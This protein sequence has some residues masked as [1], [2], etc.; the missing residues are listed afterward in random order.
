MKSVLASLVVIAFSASAF[1]GRG[2]GGG[3]GPGPGH[4]HGGGGYHHG[5]NSNEVASIL[6]AY[7]G[8]LMLTSATACGSGDGCAYK[9]MIVDSKED[10]AF[11]IA[12]DGEEKGVK[13]IRAVE[14]LRKLDPATQSTELEFAEDI[15][16]W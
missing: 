16:N 3:Y 12:T 6:S 1:A 4:G 11:Y 10:A 2:H 8:V 5:D 7:T 15:V 13:F 9:Q 14:L